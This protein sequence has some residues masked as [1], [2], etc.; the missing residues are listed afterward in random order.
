RPAPAQPF[1]ASDRAYFQVHR[2]DPARGVYIS[3]PVR[4]K[5]VED[6]RIVAS[7]RLADS[8]GRFQGV[9]MGVL[10]PEEIASAFRQQNTGNALRI[11]LY[12][13]DGTVL[14]HHPHEYHA[15][16]D[17]SA[18]FAK[19]EP[20]RGETRHASIPLSIGERRIAYH[21]IE[22][23][24]LILAVAYDSDAVLAPWRASLAGY[25]AWAAGVVAITLTVL[26]MLLVMLYHRESAVRALAVSEGRLATLIA[27]MSDWVWEQD[28]ELRFTYVSNHELKRVGL[29]AGK[30]IGKRREEIC[31]DPDTEEM[32]RHRADLDARRPFRDLLVPRRRA[33]GESVYFSISGSPVFDESGRFLGYRGTGRD[34][35]AVKTAELRAEASAAEVRRSR[36]LLQAV[37]NN[38]PARIHLK[39]LDRRYLMVN[40]E[41]LH[42]WGVTLDEAL[43]RRFDEVPV[44]NVGEEDRR[45]R[46]DATAAKELA[47]LASGK[48]ETYYQDLYSSGHD[49][50]RSYIASKIPLLGEDGRPNAILTVAT[51]VSNIRN[52]EKQAKTAVA[53][54]K[55]NRDLLQAVLDNVPARVSVKDRDRRFVLVNKFGLESWGVAAEQAI[56]RRREE[57]ISP[58]S[59]QAHDHVVAM[60]ASRDERV[61]ETGESLLFYEESWPGN[62]GVEKH[63][64]VSKVPLRDEAGAVESVMTVSMDITPMKQAEK[65]V[66]AALAELKKNRDLLQA[67]LDTVPALINV[68]DAER[69]FIL[70]NRAHLEDFRVE[71]DQVLGKRLEEVAVRS[72]KPEQF[73]AFAANIAALDTALLEGAETALNFEEAFTTPEGKPAHWLT[74]KIPLRGADGRPYAILTASIDITARKEAEMKVREANQRLADYVE[75]SSD[76]FWETAAAHRYSYFSDGLQRVL[77][78]DPARA[79]GK[80]RMELAADHGADSEKWLKHVADL[81]ARRPFRDL[82]YQIEIAGQRRHVAASGKPVFD[83][84]GRF[85]GYRGVGRDAT[86]EMAMKQ[87]LIEARDAAEVA[88]RAKSEFL[89]N[90]SHELRTPLNAVI[91]F[92][93]M[94]ATG[95]AGPLTAKQNEYLHDIGASGRH[96][97]DVINDVLDLAKIEAGRMDLREE[98]LDV[99]GVVADCTR[100]VRERARNGGVE[101]EERVAPS[102]RL[103]GDALAL[104]KIV[105]NLLSNAVKFTEPGGSVTIEAGID[106]AG[107]CVIAVADT[108][109]GMSPEGVEKALE[110]F[111]QVDSTLTRRHNGTGL[112]LPLAQSL[113]VRLGGRLTIDS[114]PGR[115]TTVSVAL[116]AGRVLH[117]AA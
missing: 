77:D 42:L 108:G 8:R 7:L 11:T 43:G 66:E 81:E 92:S 62:D 83:A 103:H 31:A 12:R 59:A 93:D 106:A 100:L 114:A 13:D 14:A 6:W 65:R 23:L 56:G 78:A 67:V 21:A 55:K 52:A 84:Q 49:A 20:V 96:L 58:R 24:P 53:E 35:T 89:A 110:L 18:E 9:V 102:L 109:I 34:I 101:L 74:S 68:K 112:G 22:G 47:V 40:D 117:S 2:D 71:L 29:D 19:F 41:Q 82:V 88:S 70:M 16:G 86:A 38:V 30:T 105:T 54:L 64:L 15:I 116:P 51:D 76:W 113:A 5:V 37:L 36:D 17:K 69:R 97:L 3:D 94:L 115:G 32:R 46:A 28:A 4:G 95:L 104:K 10:S 50:T 48:A 85:Q 80:S 87:A 98:L 111:G 79:L 26:L 61:L 45:R 90:M 72:I 1:D 75:T 27:S 39:D 73:P 107:E 44:K 57:F 25:A 60:V 33:G 91:G 63:N 99:A